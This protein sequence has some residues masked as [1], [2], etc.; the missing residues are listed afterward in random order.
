MRP[1]QSSVTKL[2]STL[3]LIPLLAIPL[4]LGW[5]FSAVAAEEKPI[6][7]GVVTFLSGGAAG[8]FGVPA[9]NGAEV[10]T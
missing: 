2:F 1:K 10:L 5:S 7:I 8:P 6:K 9:R 4:T 3:V